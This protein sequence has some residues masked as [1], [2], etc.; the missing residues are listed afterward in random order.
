MDKKELT[1]FKKFVAENKSLLFTIPVFAVLLIIVLFVY[2]FNGNNKNDQVEVVSPTPSASAVSNTQTAKPTSTPAPTTS[3]TE[4]TTLPDTERDKDSDEILRNPFASPYKVSGIIYDSKGG[5]VA[6]VEAENK[7]FIVKEGDNAENY[8]T[9]LN[10]ERDSVIIE[11]D[12]ETI[13]ISLIKN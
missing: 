9:V 1:G 5:S 13:T 11:V 2:V 8:F 3:G 7:S 6:I 4:V 12:G 10:I